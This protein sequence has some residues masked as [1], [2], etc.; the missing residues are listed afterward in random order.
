MNTLIRDKAI[1]EGECCQGCTIYFVRAHGRKTWCRFCWD[2]LSY[3]QK[4]SNWHN[5]AT[6]PT[7]GEI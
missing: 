5:K 7:L 4:Q 3:K 2:R 1:K 6:L